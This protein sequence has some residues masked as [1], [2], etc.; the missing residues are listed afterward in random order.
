MRDFSVADRFP[1]PLADPEPEASSLPLTTGDAARLLRVSTE[2]VR[3][4]VRQHRLACTTLKNGHRLFEERE[5][6]RFVAER[7]YLALAPPPPRGG[8]RRGSVG[9]LKLR[10][11][12]TTDGAKGRLRILK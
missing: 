4:Y 2:M 9:Q 3:E 10:L 12:R 8:R 6:Q 11:F 1:W 7:A 5:V